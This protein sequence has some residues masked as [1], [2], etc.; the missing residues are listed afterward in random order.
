MCAPP[1]GRC[2]CAPGWW[3]ADCSYPSE[4]AFRG[5]PNDCTHND[6]APLHCERPITT[7]KR[8]PPNRTLAPAE[9]RS[10]LQSALKRLTPLCD[11]NRAKF[12]DVMATAQQLQSILTNEETRG[13]RG[14]G[15]QGRLTLKSRGSMRGKRSQ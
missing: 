7:T 8:P 6:S 2:D 4:P 14:R 5:R 13:G 15:G 11:A 3:G 10:G 12:S 1:L 9:C